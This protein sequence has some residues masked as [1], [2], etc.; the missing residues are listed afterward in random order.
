MN[1]NKLISVFIF[2]ALVFSLNSCQDDF[3]TE[4][5]KDFL[6]PSNFY[7]TEADA[8]A[9]LI[10]AYSGLRD[11]YRQD[12][13]MLGD[14]PS[15]QTNFGTGSNVDRININNFVFDPTNSITTNVWANSYDNI[16]RANAV[17][18]R[19]PQ[20]DMNPEKRA[21][22]VGEAYFLRALNY[23]NL[24][25]V[26]GGVPLR[27]EET[28]SL[29]SLDISRSSVDEVYDVMIA[30]LKEAEKVLPNQR[31]GSDIGRATKGAAS[32]LLA[33]VYLIKQDWINAFDKSQ[34]VID[35]ANSYGYGLYTNYADLWKIENENKLEHIFM[36]QFQSGPEGLGSPYNHFFL[37]RQAN[38]IQHEGSSY[39]IHLVEND[40]WASFA[41]EDTRRDASILSSFVDPATGNIV[42]YPDNGLT[43]LSIFKYYDPTPF[44]RSN[45]DNNYPVLRYADLFL[46]K[47]EALNETNNGPTTEAYEAIN[48]IRRRANLQDLASGMSQQEFRDAVLQ[49]RSWEFCFE[50][51]R[52]FDLTRTETL[53]PVMTASGKN[54]KPKNL[55]FPIPQREI[56][57][58]N[59][60]TQADQNP[61][62]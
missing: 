8:Q 12:F 40:F 38:A 14:M 5:P 56:D 39:A 55:L 50:S 6:S 33:Y 18:A 61:G 54:P 60:I 43:Q 49:E 15:E 28:T 11:V 51:R 23:F 37:S 19:V 4:N 20:I 24:V 22:I 32:T 59:S 46:M 35:N 58:N 10:A 9:A 3:L 27:I 34:E 26:F 57:I 30:D 16:N 21:V 29:A 36:I 52:Y 44:A 1:T 31:A 17:I 48:M 45:N 62:Y 42:S 2:T 53:V 7:T 13:Y 25:R 47:A 41:P